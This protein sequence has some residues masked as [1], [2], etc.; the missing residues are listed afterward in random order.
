LTEVGIGNESLPNRVEFLRDWLSDQRLSS[1][2][3]TYY[4]CC[5]FIS[6]CG[7]PGGGLDRFSHVAHMIL[8]PSITPQSTIGIRIRGPRV[9]HLLAIT[10]DTTHP[11]LLITGIIISNCDSGRYSTSPKMPA[12]TP[13]C[14]FD[15]R[16][17]Q[18]S[19]ITCE[20]SAQQP[21]PTEAAF[22]M[23]T[24]LFFAGGWTLKNV[25]SFFPGVSLGF[26]YP[27]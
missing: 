8:N 1:G 23:L 11:S 17:Q 14:L 5:S 15:I 25:L 21:S 4:R 26:M 20:L 7:P 19:S 22:V 24:A 10:P 9:L 13:R 16:A 18:E 12:K 2:N 27:D 6:N 3:Y